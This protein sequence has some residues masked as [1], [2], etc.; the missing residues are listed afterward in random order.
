MLNVYSDFPGKN[1]EVVCTTYNFLWKTCN[2]LHFKIADKDI[3]QTNGNIFCT[4]WVKFDTQ[5]KNS[6]KLK[7]K[8][9]ADWFSVLCN[10]VTCTT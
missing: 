3:L 2:S 8:C 7:K 6:M 10:K 4:D 5:D 9:I 1:K